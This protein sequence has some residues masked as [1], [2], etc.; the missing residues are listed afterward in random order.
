MGA[1]GLSAECVFG[2]LTLRF[3]WLTL[4]ILL[5]WLSCSVSHVHVVISV[6]CQLIVS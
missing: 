1:C 3:D 6:L 4:Y 2:S 5:P